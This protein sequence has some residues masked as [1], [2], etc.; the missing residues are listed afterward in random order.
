MQP[1]SIQPLP[2]LPDA[3][4]SNLASRSFSTSIP[5]SSLLLN[6]PTVQTLK[7][8]KSGGDELQPAATTPQLP[9]ME[10]NTSLGELLTSLGEH[11]ELQEGLR[12]IMQ[13]S[14]R[15]IQKI[16]VSSNV[17]SVSPNT[18]QDTPSEVPPRR[19]VVAQVIQRTTL[20]P[21]PAAVSHPPTTK[22]HAPLPASTSLVPNP[23]PISSG[24][25]PVY[26]PLVFPRD[27]PPV[28]NPAPNPPSPL[29]ISIPVLPPLS[30]PPSPSAS[31]PTL[32][33]PVDQEPMDVDVGQTVV[34]EALDRPPHLLDHDYC[35]YNPTLPG[36][37]QQVSL[38][39]SVHRETFFWVLTHQEFQLLT[40]RSL[41]WCLS[42]TAATGYYYW[43]QV[44]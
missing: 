41:A 19:P 36:G 38:S 15:L 20:S 17:L 32:M 30:L 26:L 42:L 34:P 33:Q 35:L 40:I 28:A 12:A 3:T 13:N 1:S 31:T 10:A 29:P 43:V 18:R 2:V 24:H 16:S 21:S 8:S 25:P 23:P 27:T 4:S 9:L 37:A 22:L 11:P 7:D 6:P 39:P 14:S 44:F 5:S